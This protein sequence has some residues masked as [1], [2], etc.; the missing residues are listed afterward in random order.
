LQVPIGAVKTSVQGS[1]VEVLV[2]GA[3]QRKTVTTG[4]SNDTMI[5]IL[6]GLEEGEEVV[7]QTTSGTSTSASVSGSSNRDTGPGGMGVMGIMR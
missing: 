5:E 3:P 7:T 4:I 1:Y 6:S 2:D